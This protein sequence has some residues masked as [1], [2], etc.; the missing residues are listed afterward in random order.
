MI[1][2]L[3]SLFE[4]QINLQT[5]L[6]NI[7]FDDLK[8]QQEFIN[9]TILACL[10]ELAECL[11]ETAWKNPKLI[12]GGWKKHQELNEDLFKEEIIDL[13]HFVINLSIAAG[14][15]Q[16]ELYDRFCNKNKLNHKRQDKNY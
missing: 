6:K 7:P 15:D 8:H 5:R 13:W 9:I 16:N 2:K 14:M 11:R 4:K 1:D 10:D 3:D 12:N